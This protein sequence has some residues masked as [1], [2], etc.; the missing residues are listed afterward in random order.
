MNET[1]SEPKPGE[2]WLPY[3][4]RER[5]FSDLMLEAWGHIEFNV[6]QIVAIEMGVPLVSYLQRVRK[7]LEKISFQV[8]LD[9]LKENGVITKDEYSIIKKF[10]EYR[11][12]LFHG[13]RSF[14]LKLSEEKQDE[15]MDIAYKSAHLTTE[16]IARVTMPKELK[17]GK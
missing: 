5:R 1:K 16:I 15:I 4:R 9:F 2:A 14:F 12:K 7:L 17:N 3:L 6:D 11:N 13:K 8:K 10:Q